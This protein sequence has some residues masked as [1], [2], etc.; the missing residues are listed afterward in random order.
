MRH[1]VVSFS[2]GES[3]NVVVAQTAE[4]QVQGLAGWG[5]LP[6]ASGEGMLFAF[7]E[8]STHRMWMKGMRFSIDMVFI[9]GI[10]VVQIERALIPGSEALEGNVPSDYVLELPAR[11]SSRLSLGDKMNVRFL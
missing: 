4:E 5:A 1:A 3:F 8:R 7:G 6:S 9:A 10:T 2:N 11:W